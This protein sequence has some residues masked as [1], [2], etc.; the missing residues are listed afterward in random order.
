MTY[1][2][3]NEGKWPENQNRVEI[4]CDESHPLVVIRDLFKTKYEGKD[5]HPDRNHQVQMAVLSLR[6]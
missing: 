6:A 4:R 1:F 2:L 3:Q 5:A